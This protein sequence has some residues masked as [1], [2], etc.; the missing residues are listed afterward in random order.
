MNDW[1]LLQAYAERGSEDAFRELVHRHLALV[2][3]AARR[4]VDDAQMAED[5]AQAVFTLLAQKAGTLG[6]NTV[7]AGWLWQTTRF[8]AARA[9]RT[10]IRRQRR[11]QEAYV[12]QM[13]SNATRRSSEPEIPPW[14][15]EALASLG[16]TDRA[17]LLLRYSQERSLKEIGTELGVSEEAAKKRVTRAM[18]RLRSFASGRGIVL[19]AAALDTALSTP[20]AEAVELALRERI[21]AGALQGANAAA[22]AAGGVSAA[23]VAETLAAWRLARVRFGAAVAGMVGVVGV[24]VALWTGLLPTPLRVRD[25]PGLVATS[26]PTVDA[27]A[28]PSPSAARTVPVWP[29]GGGTLQF[30][31]V[32]K[33]SGEPVANARI[34]AN[35]VYGGKWVPRFDLRTDAKGLARVNLPPNLTRLDIGVY[36]DGWAARYATFRPHMGDLVPD[37]YVLRVAR[38]T[39]A[40]G[41]VIRRVDGR[42]VE[43]AEIQF[44]FRDVGDSSNRETPRERD[45]VAVWGAS[46]AV[47]GPDGRWKIALLPP[48][49]AGVVGVVAHP[50]FR[51][52]PLN[53]T[54]NGWAEMHQ[55]RLVTTLDPG[56]I[57]RGRVFGPGGAPVPGA[58][59]THNPYAVDSVPLVTDAEGR[60]EF[61]QLDAGSF[62]FAVTAEGYSPQVIDTTVMASMPDLEVRLGPAGLLR[63]RAVDTDGV[64]VPGVDFGIEEWDGHRQRFRWRA[65]SGPD[66]RLE[67]TSAPATGEMELYAMK[68]G[69]CVARDLKYRSGPE[70]H[71]VMLRRIHH[72]TVRALDS[73]TGEPVG[74]FKAFPGY[75]SGDG[76]EIWERLDTRHAKGG[77]VVVEFSESRLPWRIRVE[78]DGYEPAITGVLEESLPKTL[79][80]RLERRDPGRAVRGVVVL[81]DGT[82][83][84]DAE[85]ALLTLEHNVTLGLGRFERVDG[86]PLVVRTGANGQFEF[87]ADSRAHTVVAVSPTGYVRQRIRD[88]SRPMTLRLE[89]WGRIEGV[90]DAQCGLK[91]GETVHLADP[92]ALNY[93]GRLIISHLA[94]TGFPDAQ[95]RFVIEP[96]PPGEWVLSINQGVGKQNRDSTPV[97]VEPGRASIVTLRRAGP[98]VRGRFVLT[99]GSDA[100]KLIG[101]AHVVSVLPPVDEPG[102]RAGL[103]SMEAVEYWL[104]PPGLAR[105]R[106]GGNVRVSIAADGRF[107]SEDGLPPGDY[108]LRYGMNDRLYESA[109]RIDA[110]AKDAAE[111]DLGEIVAGRQ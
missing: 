20:R 30:N 44:Q 16:E 110:E 108:R 55:G 79:E 39:N 33:E 85:V 80:I 107:V 5:V 52:V 81:P 24:A 57:L 101:F 96:V 104:S 84:A 59:V 109:V 71:T 48:G 91:P 82:P 78:A 56:L 83:A 15:D 32:D 67:W 47:S 14:L 13:D 102:A 21:A 90:V 63:L 97:T 31:A 28:M 7:V 4:Q 2:L 64:E 25:N 86:D 103:H 38:V 17:A 77:D 53:L 45:G 8:V 93:S 40:V 73:S 88:T 35:A 18:E 65:T 19:T 61:R 94:D 46:A 1:E 89:P 54:G 51:R 37:S 34:V 6:R 12:M 69:W 98:F 36:S 9:R 66:G 42:P 62:D 111:V 60:F 92:C 75:G 105:A 70:E 87:R 76:P 49:D 68:D 72:V 95:G 29:M 11:E 74:K 26:T 3:S 58:V 27:N 22:S 43:G 99:E 50:D 23:L 106:R 10:E 41:G 100:T